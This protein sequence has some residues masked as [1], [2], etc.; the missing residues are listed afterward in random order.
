VTSPE[1]PRLDQQGPTAQLGKVAGRHSRRD[2]ILAAAAFVTAAVYAARVLA[3]AISW[4]Q[5]FP[6]GF[7]SLVVLNVV[8][9]LGGNAA[10]AAGFVAIGRGLP[11]RD[12]TRSPGIRL[13]AQVLVAGYVL[14][15]LHGIVY[16]VLD[17]PGEFRVHSVYQLVYP[18]LL[19]PAAILISRAFTSTPPAG[20]G[21]AAA[22]RNNRLGWASVFF[23]VG[24][25]FDALS[26]SGN[27]TLLG[28][29]VLRLIAAAVAAMALFMFA[30]AVQMDGSAMKSEFVSRERPLALAAALFLVSRSLDASSQLRLWL[31]G[32]ADWGATIFNLL[33]ALSWLLLVVAALL[34]T[35]AF[36]ASWRSGS[37]GWSLSDGEPTEATQTAVGDEA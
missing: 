11:R 15:F 23:V 2:A 5:M 8:L 14:G 7:E 19:T 13:G 37:S 1:S 12:G 29:A 36:A 22:H 9:F 3:W 17:L 35:I 33:L 4:G 28:A 31:A 32:G 24:F 18:A 10:L 16:I 26:V 6:A 21:G 20:T 27:T 25:G 34:A 30:R